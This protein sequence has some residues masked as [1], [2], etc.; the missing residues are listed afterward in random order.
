VDQQRADQRAHH[1]AGGGADVTGV[2]AGGGAAV[3]A[4]AGAGLAHGV[5]GADAD[6]AGVIALRAAITDGSAGA[7]AADA[8]LENALTPAERNEYRRLRVVYVH[9]RRQNTQDA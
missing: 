5:A 7:I 9:T 1:G 4:D 6:V 8:A 2:G 3:A